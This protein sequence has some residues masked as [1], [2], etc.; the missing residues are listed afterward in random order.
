M[1]HFLD[2]KPG[3]RVFRS[4]IGNISVGWLTVVKV[5]DELIYAGIPG[6]AMM[7]PEEA[8]T[9]DRLSGIEED[10][11]IGFGTATGLIATWLTEVKSADAT[12]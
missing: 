4:M 3:D 12:Q 8:W 6:T 7:Q 1:P 5:D 2:V 11:E 10:P 9:F